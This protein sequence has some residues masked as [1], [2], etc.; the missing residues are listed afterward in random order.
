MRFGF[1]ALW[2]ARLQKVFNVSRRT[3]QALRR[4][5]GSPAVAGTESKLAGAMGAPYGD[6]SL[7]IEQVFD[8]A[9]MILL[10]PRI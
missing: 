7:H 4:K 3:P 9:T 10:T 8:N 1:S 6:G 2:S 5:A